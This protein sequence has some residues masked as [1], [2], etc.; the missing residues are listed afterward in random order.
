MR[1]LFTLALLLL[2][3]IS[4]HAQSV[5]GRWTTIDDN[6]GKPRSVVELTEKNGKLSGRIV[7]LYE[8]EKRDKLCDKCPGD[9]HNQRVVGLEIVRDMVK[10]GKEWTKGTIL[11]PETGK[12]YDCKIWLEGGE[13]KVRGYVAFFFRTQTWVKESK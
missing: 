2:I 6:T 11:D 3:G 5:T 8:V 4:A 1:N 7:E 9:R 12:V 13:L 10:S